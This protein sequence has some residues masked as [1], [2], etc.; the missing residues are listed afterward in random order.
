MS[1]DPVISFPHA[2]YGGGVTNPT[3]QYSKWIVEDA[4][5]LITAALSVDSPYAGEGDLVPN[6]DD[7]MGTGTTGKTQHE[8]G[9]LLT[10]IDDID[11]KADY[12]DFLETAIDIVNDTLDLATFD[13]IVES[14]E[15]RVKP[16]YLR[17]MSRLASSL[18]DINAVNGSA[19]IFGMASINRQMLDDVDTYR[20]T[21][22]SNLMLQGI[23]GTAG[24]L[25]EARFKKVDTRR[26][27]VTLQAEINRL[28]HIAKIDQQVNR[29]GYEVHDA[30]Y[31]FEILSHG[32][33]FLATAGGAQ[34][35][36][37][38]MSPAQS[39]LSGA[40]VGASVGNLVAPGPVGAGIGA[41]I[42]AV[43]GALSA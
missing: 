40:S 6:P 9:K 31:D 4:A 11:I 43:V 25:M 34:L 18:A 15:K 28:R 17:A 26:L 27:V 12:R 19:F 36:P 20:R 2:E 37:P 14:H 39:A 13:R 10:D 30:F 23:S 5:D 32:F 38:K 29:V 35:M 22:E 24:M 33:N 16:Q 8:M 1:G 3:A 21:I 42:G 7:L 41:G